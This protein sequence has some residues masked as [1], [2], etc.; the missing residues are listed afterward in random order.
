[1]YQQ[2]SRVHEWEEIIGLLD[3][4]R[5]NMCLGRAEFIVMGIFTQDSGFKMLAETPG[6]GANGLLGL[7][8]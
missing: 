2:N 8:T 1:M 6:S 4:G 3:K 7:S 5:Q